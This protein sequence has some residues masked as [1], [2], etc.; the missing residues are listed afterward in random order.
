MKRFKKVALT[1]LSSALMAAPLLSSCAQEGGNQSEQSSRV[2]ATVKSIAITKLPTKLNY[3]SGE[4]FDPTGMVV[5]A[6]MSDGSTKEVSDYSYSKVPLQA[7]DKKIKITYKGRTAYVEISV[8]FVLRATSISIEELPTKTKYVAGERFDPTGMKVVAMMNDSTKQVVTDYDY[9]KKEPLTAKDTLVT[10]TYQNLKTS[11]VITVEEINEVGIEITTK[12]TK[13]AY[14]VG[15]KFDKTGMVVSI[16]KNDGTTAEADMSQITFDKNDALTIKDTKIKVMYKTFSATIK[17]SVSTSKLTGIVIEKEFKKKTYWAGEHLDLSGLSVLAN[18]EDGTNKKLSV[19]E[20]DI[21]KDVLKKEDV[22]VTVSFGGFKQEIG[23]TVKEKVTSVVVDSIKTVRVEAEH[24]DTS[25]AALREDFIAAGRTFVEEGDNASNG[26]NICG[27]NP[28][29]I[30]EIPLSSDKDFEVLITARMSDTNLGYDINS[31]L[32]FSVDDKVIKAD[33]VE[34]KYNGGTDYW[35]WISFKIGKVALTQG[36]H[37]FKI[38]SINQ[39]PNIDYF[40]FKVTK[41]GEE[42]GET[43]CTGLTLKTAPKKLQYTAGESFDPTGMQIEAT[44]DDLTTKVLEPTDY[45]IDKTVLTADD[46]KVTVTYEGM[47]L[48]IAIQ[49]GK[50]YFAKIDGLGEKKVEAEDLDFSQC[51]FREDMAAVGFTSYIVDNGEA[52]GG[53]SIER[54]KEGSKFSLDFLAGETSKVKFS[55]FASECNNQKFDDMVTVKVDNKMIKSNNPTMSSSASSQY[56]NWQEAVFD[57]GELAKGDHNITIEMTNGRPNLDYVSFY[58]SKYGTQ[59]IGHTLESLKIVTNPTKMEYIVGETFDKT[60]MVVEAYYSDKTHET[61]TDY[62]IDKTGALALEDTAITI[63]FGG[64]TVVLTIKVKAAVDFT[65][66]EPKTIVKEAEDADWSTLTG[67]AAGIQAEDNTH[68]SGGKSIG[69]VT[70]GYLQYT[71]ETLEE[72]NLV[73][74]VVLAKYEPIKVSDLVSS[75]QIDGKD[76][77]FD[78]I[79]LGRVDGNDF[80]NMKECAVTCGKLAAGVHTFKINF[81]GGPNLDCFKFTFTK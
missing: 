32:E 51:L 7:S 23:I 58:T 77:T 48:D 13:L 39:R 72:M 5:T 28:G 67:D 60:G 34:F 61:V 79:T 10:I 11:I 57:L 38:K 12:P 31:G 56:Y 1:L 22:K 75:F 3:E 76:A 74:T 36:N 47:T 52:S 78:D 68:S 71:F 4:I 27:Y 45:T 64:K 44:F 20:M 73:V 50:K 35:N 80:F 8:K 2:N 63:S 46:T 53:K 6:T 43:K 42:T 33:N 70:G 18:Y 37:L 24:L 29:S 69:H 16:K 19:E 21:D 17:L 62:T 49:V 54:Y 81:K 66:N 14:L 30:F 26:Q 55:I 15:E 65:V 59:E 40:D 25:K 9:D 41:Y